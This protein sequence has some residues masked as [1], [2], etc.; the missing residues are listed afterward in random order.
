MRHI[1]LKYGFQI[2][3]VL[4]CASDVG[5]FV[6]GELRKIADAG[7]VVHIVG[8]PG[9]PSFSAI[10]QNLTLAPAIPVIVA[11]CDLTLSGSLVGGSTS[12]GGDVTY[13]LTGAS[14]N[15][16]VAVFVALDTTP[17]QFFNFPLGIGGGG[18]LDVVTVG[19]ADATGGYSQTL[20]YQPSTVIGT[21]PSTFWNFFIQAVS[22]DF[23]PAGFLPTCVSD[24]ELL[25]ISIP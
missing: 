23:V 22:A 25:Q 1:A 16:L 4:A 6:V 8:V 14:S 13:A 19:F 24:I 18:A 2:A 12:A 9:T 21:G 17:F 11:A 3:H 5:F 15:S 20:V 10:V 7:L